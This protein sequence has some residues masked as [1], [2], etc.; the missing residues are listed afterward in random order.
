M[1]PAF[2]SAH[3]TSRIAGQVSGL[4]AALYLHYGLL[5]FLPLWLASRQVAT[6]Q[7]GALMAI[8]LFLRLVAVAP[9]VAWAGRHARLRDTLTVLAV[10]TGMAAGSFGLIH[11]H[12]IMLAVFVLFSLAW[13]QLPV[14]TDAYAVVAVRSRGLDFGRLRVWGSLGVIVGNAV[15]GA[16]F[17]HA[18]IA[19][20]P[21]LSAGLLFLL[22]VV[23]RLTSTD[24]RFSDRE[25]GAL[26]GDWKV[27]LRDRP[28]LAAMV[29]TSLVAG[30][31]GV[32]NSFAP[33]QWA[34]RGWSTTDTGLLVSL[35]IL[36]EVI[37]LW[38]GQRLLRGADPRL[39]IA[40]GA[41]FGA[42][43]W[44]GMAFTPPLPVVMTLQLLGAVTSMG[45]V[46]GVM[47]LIARRTPAH[48]VGA[49]QGLNAVL[50]GL[51][52]SIVTVGSGYLWQC[53]AAVAYGAMA[54]MAVLALPLLRVRHHA[55]TS[56]DGAQG[57]GETSDMVGI[58][59]KDTI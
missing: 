57:A 36:S 14:L 12:S 6:T 18:G 23:S 48:L 28:L 21:W 42:V 50:L 2:R 7:I 46:L 25:E 51:G 39:L 41:A 37:V 3:P 54:I 52:L 44:V 20:L 24:G 43:R 16:V 11:D 8:P 30:S 13:D 58:T 5:T 29:A 35:A 45:P 9:V 56:C 19:L 40:I 55:S 59:C 38:F 33:I 47:L 1:I 10:I 31:H 22:A 34:Q 49:A 17:D 26:A 4:F 53:G 15:G 32:L 27:V